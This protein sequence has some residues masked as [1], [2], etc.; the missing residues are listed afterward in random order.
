VCVRETLLF[1]YSFSTGR[2]CE[3]VC[4]RVEFVYEYVYVSSCSEASPR[5]SDLQADSA[6]SEAED[7]LS[8]LASEL[9]AALQCC[10]VS[11]GLDSGKAAS[12]LDIKVSQFTSESDSCIIICFNTIYSILYVI[13]S[14]GVIVKIIDI[15][16]KISFYY[17]CRN[18]FQD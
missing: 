13:L 2:H 7:G 11:V 14:C 6:H 4:P 9:W 8:S 3:C 1:V 10:W 17:G 16:T 5:P 18:V 15:D 12:R